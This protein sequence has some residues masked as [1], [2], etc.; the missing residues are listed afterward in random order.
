MTSL[1]TIR[2]GAF[3]AIVTNLREHITSA[4]AW[5]KDEKSLA[6]ATWGLVLATFLLY[7]DS[8]L[9]GKT[10]DRQW[11]QERQLRAHEQS[12]RW[13]RE[14]EIRALDGKPR[15]VVEI[16]AKRNVSEVIFQCFNLGTKTFF[17]DEIIL[18]QSDSGSRLYW[19]PD[20]PPILLPGTSVL[21]PFNCS[22]LLRA[23]GGFVEMSA[24][25]YVR[26]S[27]GIEVLPPVYF[28]YWS[29][30]GEMTVHDWNIGRL[31]D[32]LPGAIVAQPRKT[33]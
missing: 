19:K 2:Y 20:G 24:M 23:D 15:A 4:L 27:E 31:S 7:L 22:L 16:A 26:A 21:L 6:A 9:R 13:K 11:A 30:V 12:E 3:V 29:E 5:L 10:Q 25:F 17:V 14:D 8:R 33:V 28:Y 1:N 32:R 18:T